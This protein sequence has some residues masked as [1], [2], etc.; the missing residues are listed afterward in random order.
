MTCANVKRHFLVDGVVDLTTLKFFFFT[1]KQV[2]DQSLIIA[3][4]PSYSQ[5][6]IGFNLVRVCA[7]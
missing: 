7:S 4:E 3:I 2:P 1:V 5:R 6:K